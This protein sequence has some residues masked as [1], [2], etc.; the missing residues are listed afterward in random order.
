[1]DPD[2]YQMKDIKRR[3]TRLE[4]SIDRQLAR[5]QTVLVKLLA[6]EAIADHMAVEG[7]I[8]AARTEVQDPEVIVAAT[9][10]D[11]LCEC[12]GLDCIKHSKYYD[13]G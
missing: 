8:G 11:S 4:K 1:M 6:L 3:L 2:R 7:L 13:A 9:P 12:T 10:S 5:H